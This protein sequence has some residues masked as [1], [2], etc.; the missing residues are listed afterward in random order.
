MI[1]KNYVKI[2]NYILKMI[3]HNKSNVSGRRQHIKDC[4]NICN[5]DLF[6]YLYNIDTLL[7]R[8]GELEIIK[9]R[10]IEYFEFNLKKMK[11][12]IRYYKLFKILK[13]QLKFRIVVYQ[14]FKYFITAHGIISIFLM[15]KHRNF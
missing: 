6:N 7:L 8:L 3:E 2:L 4:L 12:T 11:N 9:Q 1:D 13:N 14:R 15:V 10:S 5:A